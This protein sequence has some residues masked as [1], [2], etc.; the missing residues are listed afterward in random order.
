MPF[1]IVIRSDLSL[2][3]LA[4]IDTEI[5][6]RRRRYEEYITWNA[7]DPDVTSFEKFVEKELI[8]GLYYYVD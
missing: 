7:I 4:M 8:H 3:Q 1:T 6:S 2:V 5:E